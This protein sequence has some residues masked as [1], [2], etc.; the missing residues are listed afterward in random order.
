[1]KTDPTT[2]FS[3]RVANY[4]K[5]RP[6]YP[7]EVISFLTE[8]CAL[9]PDSTIADIGSGTGIFSALLLQNNY[10]V[11]GVE[12]NEAMR[13]SAE[14][15]FKGNKNFLSVVG[16]AEATTLRDNSVDL[17]VCAQAF[18]WFKPDETRAEFR[19][20]LKSDNDYVALIWNNRLTQIDE[21]SKAYEK[22]LEDKAT[23]YSEVNHQHLKGVDFSYFYKDEQY[24]LTKFNNTQVFDY[25]GLAG[26]AF[27]SSYV[28]P[29]DTDAGLEFAGLLKQTFDQYK[30]D[31]KVII[32]YETEVYLGKV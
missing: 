25:D 10:V 1:M 3:N 11:Y 26:R 15:Q 27:S 17:V 16:S 4:I 5:Y 19:R 21:F 14:Q 13:Q 22:L 2:R 18:H 23:D 7:D 9:N 12:P 29:Q 32:Y 8:K 24:T 6:G 28:P 20:V 30:V 31:E